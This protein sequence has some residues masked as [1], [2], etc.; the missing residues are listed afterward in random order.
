MQVPTLYALCFHLMS[1]RVQKRGLIHNKKNI[2]KLRV[3][4]NKKT[5]LKKK[6]SN[7]REGCTFKIIFKELCHKN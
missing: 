3:R 2:Y 5:K 1:Y 4:G 7:L 6:Q